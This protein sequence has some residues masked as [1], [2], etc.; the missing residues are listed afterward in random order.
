MATLSGTTGR[1]QTTTTVAKASGERSCKNSHGRRSVSVCS[2]S[3]GPRAKRPRPS[4]FVSAVSRAPRSSAKFFACVSPVLARER[5]R[6]KNGARRRYLRRAPTP[7]PEA[8]TSTAAIAQ[9]RQARQD[10]ART[11]QQH[12]PV[13]IRPPW[14]RKVPFLRGT[15]GGSGARHTLLRPPYAPC[16]SD[17]RKRAAMAVR[18]RGT[19]R[20]T[21]DEGACHHGVAALTSARSRHPAPP[22]G[23]A[24]EPVFDIAVFLRHLSRACGPCKTAPAAPKPPIH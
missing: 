11:D 12:L 16:L 4:P 23:D 24:E 1:A 2:D 5:S 8:G 7:Q 9:C 20:L 14:H 3:C 18:R 19:A 15:G 10:P 21:R 13:A 6:R 17:V 22:A